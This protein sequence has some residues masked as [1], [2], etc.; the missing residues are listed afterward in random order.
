MSE[1]INNI[2]VGLIAI[3]FFGSIFIHEQLAV[4]AYLLIFL[5]IF[6][7][8]K[9]AIQ[10]LS[11]HFIILFLNPAIWSQP[12]WLNVMRWIVL[13]LAGIRII[14]LLTIK[15]FVRYV[16]P[17]LVFMTMVIFLSYFASPYFN[18]SVLKVVNFAF[19]ASV[20][21]IAYNSLKIE[22]LEQLKKWFICIGVVIIF[23]SIPTLAVPK[24]GYFRNG[25][26]FQGIFN[27][28][29]LFGTFLT[30]IIG[31][32]FSDILLKENKTRILK[33]I[34]FF[35]GLLLIYFSRSRT[36]LMAFLLCMGITV[37]ISI[38][39][40]SI[41][42][43]KIIDSLSS[44]KIIFR[45]G[46]LLVFLVAISFHPSFSE[47]IDQFWLKTSERG[48]VSA[49]FHES[50]GQ[51]VVFCWNRF[52][53]RPWTG[54]G[55]GID[56]AHKNQRNIKTF[57]G[58]PISAAAEKGFLPVAFLEEVGILGLLFFLPFLASFIWSALST[59]DVRLMAVFSA[60][61]FVNIGEAVFFSSGSLGGYLWL[62]MGLSTAGGWS[63]QQQSAL[64]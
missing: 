31:F 42:L 19:Y 21:L 13:F 49:A 2:I 16:F 37:L 4:I 59:K 25:T 29:Q 40:Q 28:P 15:S 44:F 8:A 14:P 20:V 12:S 58:I 22:E 51:G 32:L 24:I 36:A 48:S 62:L 57:M 43:K 38:S 30:P 56:V 23:I 61:L 33:S 7:G 5:L 54:N 3:F 26:G 35:L 6:F 46:I 39:L 45:V 63:R 27:Q 50:R 60:C 41:G 18:I 1:I 11:L 47:K 52:L 17:L 55:F 53:K 64:F 10:A 9:Q 34:I